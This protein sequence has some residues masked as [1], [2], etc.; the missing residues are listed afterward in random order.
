MVTV[1]P[2]S[3][4]QYDPYSETD[5]E[6]VT[7]RKQAWRIFEEAEASRTHE[8]IAKNLASNSCCVPLALLWRSGLVR[9]R[10]ESRCYKF[11]RAYWHLGLNSRPENKIHQKEK[12][13]AGMGDLVTAGFI[14]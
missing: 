8:C 12:N 13:A 6:R 11:S 14:P 2:I 7:V 1:K 10:D 4:I 3:L 9:H 5:W